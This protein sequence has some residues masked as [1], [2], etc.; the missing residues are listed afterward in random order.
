[1]TQTRDQRTKEQFE[2]LLTYLEQ[3]GVIAPD[4]AESIRRV[5]DHGQGN[6]IARAAREGRGPPDHANSGGNGGN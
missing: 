4:W 3:E 1:M 6:E 2:A 5:R